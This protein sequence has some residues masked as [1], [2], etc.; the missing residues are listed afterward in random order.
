MRHVGAVGLFGERLHSEG[1][2]SVVVNQLRTRFLEQFS[3]QGCKRLLRR[4][5]GAAYD[6]PTIGVADDHPPVSDIGC[7]G[8]VADQM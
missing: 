8:N 3:S 6:T 1:A 2:E 4:F 7:H 5:E